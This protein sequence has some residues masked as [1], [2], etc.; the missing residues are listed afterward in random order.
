MELT[1]IL[2]AILGANLFVLL[3]NVV[4]WMLVSRVDIR[5]RKRKQ[6]INDEYNQIIANANQKAAEVI[7]QANNK[8]S[9]L[10]EKTEFQIEDLREAARQNYQRVQGQHLQQ[11]ETFLKG[12]KED[13]QNF[14]VQLRENLVK[15]AK[16]ISLQSVEGI[17]TQS[18][19]ILS[20][21]KEKVAHSE[22]DIAKQISSSIQSANQE[23]EKYK[24]QQMD[25][26]D[27][28]IVNLVKHTVEKV[29]SKSL[30]LTEHQELVI[31]ALEQS[32]KEGVI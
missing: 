26:I 5:V 14:F 23:I 20:T 11:M 17:E 3:L 7:E 10:L 31:E 8:A 6:Q 15:D 29:I 16:A 1:Y 13:E 12:I 30:N 25:R 32:K 4:F 22:E 2:L 21:L 9:K 19:K 24:Q 18:E 27:H 28:S